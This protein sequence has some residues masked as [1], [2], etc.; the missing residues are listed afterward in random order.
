[1]NV[2]L[3]LV[4]HFCWLIKSFISSGLVKSAIFAIWLSLRARLDIVVSA[5]PLVLSSSI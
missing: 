3:V 5:A 2:A 4:F 1:M